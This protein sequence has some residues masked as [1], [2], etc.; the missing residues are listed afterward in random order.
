MLR[1]IKLWL[2]V[3]IHCLIRFPRKGHRMTSYSEGI[4]LLK[5]IYIPLRNFKIY[6]ECGY[7]E[8]GR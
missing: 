7:L 2:K 4:I 3:W 6:C 5:S 1:Y 8:Q